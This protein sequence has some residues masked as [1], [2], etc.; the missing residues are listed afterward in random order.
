[1]TLRIN[2]NILPDLLY[3]IQQSSQNTATATQQ[4]ASG[5]NVNQLSDNPSAA[6]SLVANHAQTSQDDQFLQNISSLNSRFQLADSTL[7]N[8]VT[9]ITRAITLGTEGAN[10]TQ[11]AADQQAIA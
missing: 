11:S 8:V 5:R 3:A 7:S 1:M 6:A 4:L 9:V 10:G 2:P